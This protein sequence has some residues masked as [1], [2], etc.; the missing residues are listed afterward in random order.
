MFTIF[1]N[2]NTQNTTLLDTVPNFLLT[3]SGK[4]W[5]ITSLSWPG[6]CLLRSQFNQK[7]GLQLPLYC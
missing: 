5:E 7:L 2:F 3:V 1:Y 6:P 4:T